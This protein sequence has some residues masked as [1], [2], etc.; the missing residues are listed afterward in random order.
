MSNPNFGAI[1]AYATIEEACAA[2]TN[3]VDNDQLT[4]YEIRI[5]LGFFKPAERPVAW[6]ILKELI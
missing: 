1:S 2:W 3:I 5:G 4:I 6:V